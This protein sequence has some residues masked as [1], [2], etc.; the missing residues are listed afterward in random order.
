MSVTTYP[1]DPAFPPPDCEDTGLTKRE[2]FAGLAMQTLSET[3][4]RNQSYAEQ[5][6]VAVLKADAL[7][8]ALNRQPSTPLEV[9][10]DVQSSNCSTALQL[11]DGLLESLIPHV[12]DK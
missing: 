10:K 1:Y 4:Y 5:A 2:Y 3:A 11:P 12:I 7:I 9:T 8:A 6:R